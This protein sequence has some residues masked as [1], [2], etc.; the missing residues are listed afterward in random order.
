MAAITKKLIACGIFAVVTAAQVT[1]FAAQPSSFDPNE[2]PDP[3]ALVAYKRFWDAFQDYETKK[4]STSV[5][6]YQR[7]RDGLQ[8]MYSGKEKVIVEQRVATLDAAINRYNDNL[9]KTPSAINR[10]YVLLSLA[11]MHSEMASLK[12]SIG[13]GT[14]NDSRNSALAILKT[15]EEK[16][17]SFTYRTDALYLRATLLEASDE[18]RTAAEIWKKLAATGEDRFTFYGNIACGDGAFESGDPEQAIKNYERAK[19][20]LAALDESDKGLDEL[21]T[22]YRLAWSNYKAGHPNGAITA[23]RHVIAPG[24]L[25]KSVRQKDRISH[26]IGELT[27]LALYEGDNDAQIKEVLTSK[28]FQIYGAGTALVLM[29]QYQT[30]NRH[31]KALVVGNIAA[32][33]FALRRE[34]PDIL[35]AKAMTEG[36]LS[37]KASRLETLEQ[38]SMLL[39]V[40]SLWRNQHKDEP[41]VVRYMEG[42]ARSAAESVAASYYEDGLASGNPKKF[43]MAATH[44]GVLLDDQVN[45]TSAPDLRLKIANCHF[46]AGN[47]SIAEKRYGDLISSLKT[48]E[49]VLTTAHFQRVLTLEKIW[50]SSYESA[51]Q[52][53]T[54][55]ISNPPALEAL[56][57]LEAAV[58]EHA[59][60]FPGQSRSV[61]LLLVAAST[62]RDHNQFAQASRFWQR[63]LLSNPSTG[64]RS[65]AIRGLVFAKLRT[66]EPKDVIESVSNFLKLEKTDTLGQNLQTELLGVLA[67]AS[68]DAASKLSKAGKTDDAGRLLLKVA[69]DFPK[70]PGKEQIWRDGAYFVGISGDWSRAQSSAQ[71]YLKEG[72]KK[73]AADMTY[74][75]GRSQEYQMRFGDSAKTYINLSENFPAHVRSHVALQRAEQ[76]ALAEEDF[77]SAAHAAN[78]RGH[79]SKSKSEKLAA[80]DT[81]VSYLITAGDHTRALAIAEQR[82]AASDSNRDKLEAELSLANVRYQSGEKQTAVDDLDSIDKQIERSKFD[83]GDAYKRVSADANMRLGEHALG[84]FNEMRIEDS[85]KQLTTQIESKT[86]LFSELVTRF[87]K[88]AS[89]DQT[90]LSPK[91]RFLLGQAA[92]DFADEISAIPPRS[93]EPTTLKSQTRF[94]Q[95]LSRLK[96]M[97]RKYHGNNILSKQRS[98]QS[99]AKNEWISRSAQAIANGEIEGANSSSAGEFTSMNDGGAELADN[100]PA[101]SEDGKKS[102][103]KSKTKT[104]QIQT[105][106]QLSTASSTEMPQQWSH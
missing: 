55:P 49:G 5:E 40:Q 6:E 17:K 75:L 13:D 71:D 54:D 94:N 91:A 51:V 97:A 57:N 76:L 63:A 77:K 37:K 92:S 100:S 88:V 32:S 59:N 43:N 7:T 11:Q 64:Q 45:T 90:N 20:I 67:S 12:K 98:P 26:D 69:S 89:L 61:D 28:D 58:D 18:P 85:K 19:T 36:N 105:A 104:N 80:Y 41:D 22:Y 1:A 103:F 44:Y 38:L 15:I 48:P 33:R 8:S 46:F 53:R 68:N 47:L 106:D 10:P 42:L 29:Q 35:K 21:R 16:H 101:T 96:D 87:D 30:A 66:G 56:H 78:L 95:N 3:Q 79:Y 83:L 65:I 23:A 84:I 70:V 25:S 102:H 34:Y 27:G 62:N 4:K 81:A 9:E 31:A 50:R 2:I 24:I 52:K 72:N 99:Y 14:D 93:G 60:R 74:L 82:K 39:P 86:K 73:F